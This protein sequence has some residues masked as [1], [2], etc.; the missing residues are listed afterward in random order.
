MFLNWR[1]SLDLFREV[2]LMVLTYFC[3][4]RQVCPCNF[5]LIFF[6]RTLSFYPN[7][8]VIVL[9]DSIRMLA[10]KIDT[11]F[12]FHFIIIDLCKICRILQSSGEHNLLLIIKPLGITKRYHTNIQVHVTLM[13]RSHTNISIWHG[14]I[15]VH[16]TC[17]TKVTTSIEFWHLYWQ[18][19]HSS[20]Y[21]VRPN[22]P[23][24]LPAVSPLPGA[25]RHR[26]V[27]AARLNVGASC[28]PRSGTQPPRAEVLMLPNVTAARFL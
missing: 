11:H 28:S 20:I 4:T 18:T 1:K 16:M 17:Q 25:R 22:K 13:S 19:S 27:L 24:S 7:S 15:H 12:S 9:K 8:N 21:Y 6:Y 23:A 3:T 5:I 2:Q 14:N 10:I 26:L